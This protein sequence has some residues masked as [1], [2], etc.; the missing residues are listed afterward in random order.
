M[1]E[2]TRERNILEI[3]TINDHELVSHVLVEDNDRKTTDHKSIIIKTN[4]IRETRSDHT[5]N[6]ISNLEALNFHSDKIDWLSL[7]SEL[8]SSDWKTILEHRDVNCKYENFLA[9]VTEICMKYV[10][11]KTRKVASFLGIRGT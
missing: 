9:Y 4:L 8:G 6:N 11:L 2:A 10:P 3:F 7:K 5:N 1:H